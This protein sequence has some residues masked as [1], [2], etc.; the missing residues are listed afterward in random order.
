MDLPKTEKEIG[1][2]TPDKKRGGMKGSG[3]V[4][5]LQQV[6]PIL[7]SERWADLQENPLDTLENPTVNSFWKVTHCLKI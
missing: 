6:Q 7:F 5:T 2:C 4:I 1:I 3:D